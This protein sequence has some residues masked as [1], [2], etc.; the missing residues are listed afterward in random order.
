MNKLPIFE[1]NNAVNIDAHIRKFTTFIQRYAH[2]TAYNHEDV[3]MKL[4][5]LSLEDDA[6]QWF[7]D[8]PD[9]ASDSLQAQIFGQR[10]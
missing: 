8:K 5:V 10:T 4:F 1:G 3:R 6:L 2:V 7:Y 9:N